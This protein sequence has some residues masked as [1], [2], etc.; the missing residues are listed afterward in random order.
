M[1]PRKRTKPENR[2]LPQ[3][4]EWHGGKI[5]YQIPP[6]LAGHPAF[7]G[8][9]RRFLLGETLSSAH[10][11]WAEVQ[12]QFDLPTPNDMAALIKRF[13]EEE[14]PKKRPTTQTGYLRSL[15]KIEGVFQEFHP[16]QIR[17]SHAYAHADRVKGGKHD[18]RVLSALL[19]FAVRIGMIDHNPLV[20]Q[21]KLE[22][23]KRRSYV[24]DEELARFY[25][26]LPRKWQLYVELKLETGLR[27]SDLLQLTAQSITPD[28]LFRATQKTSKDLLFTWTPEV[29]AII[30]ELRALQQPVGSMFLFA[31]RTGQSYYNPETGRADGFQSMWQRWKKKAGVGFTEH[32]LR[33]KAASD[34]TREEAQAALGHT[35]AAMTDRYRTAPDRVKP[36]GISSRLKPKKQ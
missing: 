1:A 20:G 7:N 18:V 3:R 16:G 17:P 27:Q 25:A 31:T 29:R 8:N 23:A 33:G 12:A 13:R 32:D 9:R 15:G 28:G 10:R 4:W 34:V 21:V 19:S 24:T 2:R 5:Y 22:G 30:E 14:V 35:N 36:L 11:K 6:A 26:V